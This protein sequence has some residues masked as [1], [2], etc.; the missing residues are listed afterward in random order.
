MRGAQRPGSALRAPSN[1]SP[2][3]NDQHACLRW[4]AADEALAPPVGCRVG[5]GISQPC[6]TFD[7]WRWM[8]VVEND[9]RVSDAIVTHF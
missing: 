3:L 8:P 4:D 1:P 5:L 2:A 6:S 9:Y 7:Q